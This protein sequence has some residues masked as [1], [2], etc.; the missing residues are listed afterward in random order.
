MSAARGK[1]G[2]SAKGRKRHRVRQARYRENL[3]KKGKKV[4]DQFLNPDGG[5]GMLQVDELEVAEQAIAVLDAR[6]PDRQRF[7]A[8][9]VPPAVPG[10]GL[11]RVRPARCSVCGQVG[12]VVYRVVPGVSRELGGWLQ[13]PP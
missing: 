10:R 11:G 7:A 3:E 2:R 6:L 5:G 13:V 1:Y 4:T 9:A 8:S 12:I